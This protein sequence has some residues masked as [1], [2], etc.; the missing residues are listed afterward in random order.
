MRNILYGTRNDYKTKY[1]R[2]RLTNVSKNINNALV[3]KKK[4][5]HIFE[6]YV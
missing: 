5:S 2:L 4:V 3:V 6:K 1:T